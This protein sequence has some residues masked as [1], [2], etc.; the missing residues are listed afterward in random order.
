MSQS[1]R[2]TAYTA[3]DYERTLHNESTHGMDARV[4]IYSENHTELEAMFDVAAG[5]GMVDL[6]LI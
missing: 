6:T 5:V 3:P 2:R 1:L 4:I